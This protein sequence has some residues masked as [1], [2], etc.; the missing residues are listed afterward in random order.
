MSR[1]TPK[2]FDFV[3]I[4]M[5][6]VLVV[7]TAYIRAYNFKSHVYHFSHVFRDGQGNMKGQKMLQGVQG[8]CKGTG[9]RPYKYDSPGVVKSAIKPPSSVP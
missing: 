9:E 3:H 2:G 5:Y 4:P 8:V 6:T 1:K 7:K